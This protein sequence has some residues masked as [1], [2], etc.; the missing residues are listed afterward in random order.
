MTEMQIP[1]RAMPSSD[2]GYFALLTKA[3][4][5][6]GFRWS[7]V[8]ARWPAFEAAFDQFDIDRVAAYGPPEF[9]RLVADRSLI[10]NARKI[11]GTIHNARVLQS[12]RSEHGSVKAWL[13]SLSP[14][15]WPERRKAVAAPFHLLG[16]FGVYFFLWS[17]GEPVPPHEERDT[18]TE[19]LPP[20]APEALGRI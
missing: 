7:L 13:D 2:A 4:F 14:L 16:A 1:P 6:A 10:R 19:T 12:L 5:V 17:A 20:G 9:E 15:T 3:V 11:E 18:W 8:E